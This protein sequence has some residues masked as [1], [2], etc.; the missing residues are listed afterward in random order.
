MLDPAIPV[1][2]RKDPIHGLLTHAVDRLQL[3]AGKLIGTVFIQSF[4][5]LVAAFYAHDD[6]LLGPPVQKGFQ[7]PAFA[8]GCIGIPEQIVAVEK[9]HHRAALL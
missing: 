7:P 1:A 8:V 2:S 6:H 4:P 5:A 3:T 9:I